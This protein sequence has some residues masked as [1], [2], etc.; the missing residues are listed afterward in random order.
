MSRRSKGKYYEKKARDLL[1]SQG[2]ICE[3][4]NYSRFQGQD[5]YNL[6]DILAVK[7]HVKLIQVKT[8]ASH[9]YKARKDIA[10]WI[11]ENNISGLSCEVW[12]KE[13]RKDWRIEIINNLGNNVD[14]K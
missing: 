13:P 3:T 12:L 8:N 9:F 5:F 6:F 10:K 4:K 7:D 2:F 11:T 1:T 14:I